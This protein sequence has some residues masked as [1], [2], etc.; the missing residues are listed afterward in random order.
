MASRAEHHII[1]GHTPVLQDITFKI[2]FNYKR[3]NPEIH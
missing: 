3:F 2:L 1:E